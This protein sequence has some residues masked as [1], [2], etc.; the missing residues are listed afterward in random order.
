MQIQP[1]SPR[2]GAL[3]STGRI[4]SAAAVSFLLALFLY[5]LPASAAGDIT[6]SSDEARQGQT[7]EVYLKPAAMPQAHQ[8]PEIS[9]GKRSVKA[10]PV[11]DAGGEK[12]YRALLAVP[13]D[14]PAGTY[15][16][17]QGDEVKE[18]KV[19]SGKFPIQHIH[20]PPGKDTFASSPGEEAA[21]DKAK[22]A[23][24][25][26]RLWHGPFS[27]PSEA[28]I[29]AAFGLK[30][31][32]NGKL[33]ADYYHSGLDFAAQLGTPVRACAPGHVVMV[34]HNWRLHGNAV[35]IDHGQGVVSFYIHLQKTLVAVGDEVTAGQVIGRV[36]QTGRANGPHLHFSLYVNQVA[37]NPA[38]WF[39]QVF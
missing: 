31:M 23:L 27:R 16:I 32:V 17:K 30:R 13:A 19:V 6:L 20:L 14:L 5:C 33:L 36:G 37:T 18:L 9:F 38:D 25:S 3:Q 8:I 21:V 22:A 35:A 39:K 7:V 28:R 10:F 11:D 29:S 15:E 24:S 12:Q 2:R 26:D 34:G 1:V 4:Q